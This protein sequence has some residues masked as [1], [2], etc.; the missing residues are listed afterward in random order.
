MI[1]SKITAFDFYIVFH[2][3]YPLYFTY[4]TPLE[5]TVGA[6][7]NS[8]FYSEHP[9]NICSPV[10]QWEPTMPYTLQAL[11]INSISNFYQ[12]EQWNIFHCL[13]N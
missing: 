9:Y 12:F 7:F 8:L 13:Q 2:G 4:P 3:I 5:I 6:A 11:N 10:S 1:T